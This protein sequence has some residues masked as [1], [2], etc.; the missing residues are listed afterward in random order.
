MANRKLKLPEPKNNLPKP[1]GNASSGTT[2]GE[3]GLKR[4]LSLPPPKNDGDSNKTTTTATTPTTIRTSTT[5]P[6][7]DSQESQ[8][9]AT[10]PKRPRLEAEDAAAAS[11]KSGM[12]FTEPLQLREFLLTLQVIVVVD[13]AA[14]VIIYLTFF[15]TFFRDSS[16]LYYYNSDE[17]DVA[18]S[19]TGTLRRFHSLGSVLGT[20]VP[21]T[22]SRVES[23]PDAKKW[24]EGVADH[25]PFENLP[26]ATGTFEKMRGLL[27][28]IKDLKNSNSTS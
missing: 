15:L 8:N 3:T 12:N 16:P 9:E 21:A 1:E 6:T 23:L 25:I 18:T 7:T 19:G 28:K 27:A 22:I 11:L 26:G 10:P 4:K 17:K 2:S 13:A 5:T 24:S 20:P 14:A